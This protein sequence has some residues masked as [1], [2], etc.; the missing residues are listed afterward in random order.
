[1]PTTPPVQPAGQLQRESQLPPATAALSLNPR[2]QIV[3]ELKKSIEASERKTLSGKLLLVG[4]GILLTIEVLTVASLAAVTAVLVSNPVGW[5]I[6]AGIGGA[7]FLIGLTG[8]ALIATH[9]REKIRDILVGILRGVIA[10]LLFGIMIAALPFE[11]AAVP[12]AM[13]AAALTCVFLSPLFIIGAFFS[14]G[15][16]GIKEPFKQKGEKE[17]VGELVEEL[18]KTYKEIDPSFV[19]KETVNEKDVLDRIVK[20]E[21]T[22]AYRRLLKLW[23]DSAGDLQKKKDYARALGFL[24]IRISEGLHIK[25]KY[26]PYKNTTAKI[27]LDEIHSEEDY[28]EIALLYPLLP[29][30]KK[31]EQIGYLSRQEYYARGNVTRIA[32]EHFLEREVW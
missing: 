28:D 24:T 12:V 25:E 7:L 17:N 31:V 21:Y 26:N 14:L 10:G 16:G 13:E 22:E 5:A 18:K 23:S 15:V 20:G 4:S 30:S 11:S 3:T 9:S 27:L 19:S 32:G 2:H 8:A 6:I 1:M 29:S